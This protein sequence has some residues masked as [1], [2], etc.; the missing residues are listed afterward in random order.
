M[1]FAIHCIKQ[2]STI[3]YL[4]CQIDFKLSGEA[5]VSK[6]LKKVNA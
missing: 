1:P 3:E 6:D 4:C 2:N 5:M